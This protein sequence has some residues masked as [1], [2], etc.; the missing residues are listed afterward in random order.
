MKVSED[1]FLGTILELAERTGWT[2]Y[3][4]RPAM[5]SIQERISYRTAA[6]GNGAEGFPDLFLA[7]PSHYCIMAELKSETG[8]MTAEQER[9]RDILELSL[10]VRYFLWRPK[11][12][13]EVTQVLFEPAQGDKRGRAGQGQKLGT[14]KTPKTTTKKDSLLRKARR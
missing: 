4:P 14:L 2:A 10:G 3:H 11:D 12:W 1:N 13:D 6:Q 8:K 7:K 9:W 5:V